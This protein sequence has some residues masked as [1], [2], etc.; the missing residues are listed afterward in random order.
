MVAKSYQ[1]L[2]QVGEPFTSNGKKYIKVLTKTGT[3]KKV[4]WYSEKEYERMYPNDEK[5]KYFKTQKEVLGFKDGYI[6]IFKGSAYEDNEYFQFSDARYSKWWGW[7]FPSDIAL[8]DD[9]PENVIPITLPWEKVGNEEGVLNA[10]SAVEEAVGELIYDADISEYQG[11][12]GERLNITVEVEKT[13]DLDGY[14]GKTRVHIMRDGDG[15]CYVWT[16]AAR[17]WEV[18]TEHHIAGTVKEYKTYK[19]VKQ[20]ILTRC[21]EI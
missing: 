8:P 5:I 7:Y 14:Y 15:N 2:K 10:E 6:T 3:E 21:K 17:S 16:T 11:E 4:R 20:T 1:K 12:I 13:F 18:G 9:L 19:G